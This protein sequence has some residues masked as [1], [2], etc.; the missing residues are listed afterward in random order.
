MSRQKFFSLLI[1][2]T[3]FAITVKVGLASPFAASLPAQGVETPLVSPAPT[4]IS[5]SAILTAPANQTAD[6][7]AQTTCY[8][9]Y[10]RFE[11]IN[12]GTGANGGVQKIATTT[13]PSGPT[14]TDSQSL[15]G[16][17]QEISRFYSDPPLSSDFNFVDAITG[18]FWVDI[19]GD[20]NAELKVSMYDYDPVSGAAVP[21]GEASPGTFLPAD[22]T[23]V[24]FTIA[25][26]ATAVAGGHRFLFILEGK[27]S[28]GGASPT[29]NLLYNSSDKASHFT[30]CRP[31]PPILTITKIGSLG[32]GIGEPIN[33]KIVISNAGETAATNLVIS[34]TIPQNAF[35]T[36]GGG[37]Q[38]GNII[39][40][41]EA[42]LLP[43]ETI[44][45]P[46]VLTATQT[47]TNSD[48]RVTADGGVS[49][50]G[51]EAVVTI[52]SPPGQP[53]LTVLKTGPATAAPNEFITYSLIVTNSGD[54]EAEDLV[55]NDLLPVG[56]TYV[57]GGT[58]VG[59]VIQWTA[60]SLA[61]DSSLEFNFTVTAQETIVNENYRVWAEN[62]PEFIGQKLV[63]VEIIPQAPLIQ[64]LFL[65]LLLKPGPLTTL[66]INSDNTGGINPVQ[67]LHADND[68]ELLR[69]TVENNVQKVCGQFPT[70]ADGRYKIVA[71]TVNCGTLQG[72]F[73]DAAPGATVTR[74]IFCN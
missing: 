57:S 7:T 50:V 34:D 17:Y 22:E 58:R 63:A 36:I 65:P 61:A 39:R 45:I 55:V 37:V 53:N 51:Q 72:T 35:Y 12:V 59:N 2:F 74:R 14:T 21:L 43:G 70:P 56:A 24:P 11:F 64:S 46:F 19:I 28:G 3:L 10:F 68:S 4:V 41:Q 49:A 29:V 60:D 52:I 18:A 15:L 69:C 5:A 73:S 44:Q 48:Y 30:V 47:I 31:T 6:V 54:V 40:W 62:A 27:K 20:A 8:N 23:E 42:I 66:V 33:Y 67:V 25:Q 32:A 16:S 9:Y 1:T 26:P 13:L 38:V 71:V